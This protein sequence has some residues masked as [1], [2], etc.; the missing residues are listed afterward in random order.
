MRRYRAVEAKLPKYRNQQEKRRM[1][2]HMKMLAFVVF[3][4]ALGR[5]YSLFCPSTHFISCFFIVEHILNMISIWY[6]SAN[7][8]NQSEPAKEL[9]KANLSQLFQ[10]VEFSYWSA[11]IGKIVN[12]SA[13]FAWNYMDLFVMVISLGFSSRFKQINDDLH[14]IKG[15]V[16]S[17]VFS[18]IIKYS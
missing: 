2:F 11:F 7:C 13:T 3:L 8:L 6:Y 15:E 10:F 14:R 9:L 12:I 16:I 18:L 5:C 1:A 4:C 17:V